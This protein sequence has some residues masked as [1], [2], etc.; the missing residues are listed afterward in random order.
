[1]EDKCWDEVLPAIIFAWNS[2]V[3]ST[4][5]YSPF[6]VVFGQRPRFPLTNTIIPRDLDSTPKDVRSY[7]KAQKNKIDIIQSHVKE[8]IIDSHIKMLDNANKDIITETIFEN[9]NYVF[10]SENPTGQGQ[11]LKYKFTGP[12][13]IENVLTDHM[14]LLRDPTGKRQFNDGIHKDRLKQGYIRKPNP[15]PYFKVIKTSKDIK[16]V[17]AETQTSIVKQ[18]AAVTPVQEIRTSKRQ[19]RKPIRFRDYNHVDPIEEVTGH[20][21][22]SDSDGF[23]KVKRILAQRLNGERREY[24]VHVSG[25]PADNAIWVPFSNLNA[26]A[27]FAI[28]K[29]PPPLL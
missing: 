5:R 1:M 10:L 24:L 11:K 27:R 21:V 22:S 26:K 19:V 18:N 7:L 3:H 17:N 13:V 6:E 12:F 28:E 16:F 14:V 23:H 8:N 2:S 29:R 4:L 9:G 15:S 25:E 20:S